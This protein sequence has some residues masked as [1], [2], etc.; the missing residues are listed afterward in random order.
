MTNRQKKILLVLALLTGTILVAGLLYFLIQSGYLETIIASIN[1]DL[2]PLVFILLLLIFPAL[3]FP[4]SIFLIVA[5]IKFGIGYGILLWLMI[6]PIHSTIGFMAAKYLRPLLEKLLNFFLDYTIPAIPK[7]NEAMF[8]F[9][10][11][12]VPGL[13]YAAKN[14]LLP[15]AG[16][17]FRYCIIMNCIVQGFLGTPFVILGKSGAEMDPTLFYVAVFGLALLFF[18]LRWLKKKYGNNS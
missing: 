17:S 16:V 8:S 9:L 12:A 13:P 1:K 18:L 15:L 4:I 14:Y 2:P 11:L 5:G 3:G 7:R 6:L 10:F